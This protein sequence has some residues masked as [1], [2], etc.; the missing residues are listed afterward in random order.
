MGDSPFKLDYSG[1]DRDNINNIIQNQSDSNNN[2]V[3][4]SVKLTNTDKN[5]PEK[6][7]I[8]FKS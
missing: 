1:H 5:C 3:L 7:R 4:K 6:I 8:L 2:D